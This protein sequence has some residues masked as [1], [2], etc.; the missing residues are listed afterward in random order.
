[1][2]HTDTNSEARE[3]EAAVRER[4][5]V[6]RAWGAEATVAATGLVEVAKVEAV[7]ASEEVARAAVERVRAAVVRV[8]VGRSPLAEPAEERA[9]AGW[10]AAP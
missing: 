8:A 9:V 5:A 4:A 7:R 2:A 10:V 1:M 6:E 3:P